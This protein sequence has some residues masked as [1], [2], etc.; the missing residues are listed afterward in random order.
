MFQQGKSS[1]VFTNCLLTYNNSARGYGGGLYLSPLAT[2]S[3]SRCTLVGNFA[4]FSRSGLYL[5]TNV[6]LAVSNSILWRNAGG[7]IETNGANVHLAF[8]LNDSADPLFVG[9]GT[10]SNLFVDGAVA[11]AGSGTAADPYCDLQ[12]GLDGFDFRLATNSPCL[13][14]ASDGGNQGATTG[15]G[16]AA[17]GTVATL[18]LVNGVYDIRGRNIIFTR[19]LQGNG[20]TNSFIGNGVFG[21]VEDTFLRDLAIT[22]ERWFGG[23]V[24]RNSALMERSRVFSNE[25]LHDGGGIYISAGTCVL[26]NS[27]VDVN[28]AQ[29]RGGGVW[30][31]DGL[32]FASDQSGLLDNQSVHH[33]GGL[34]VAPDATAWITNA[35]L[36]RLNRNNYNGLDPAAEGGGV[37][38]LDAEH[39]LV[40]DSGVEQNASSSNGG[41]VRVGCP[42]D[43]VHSWFSTN[44]SLEA[45]GGGIYSSGALVVTNCLIEANTANYYPHDGGGLFVSAGSAQLYDSEFLRN[46]AADF[47]GGLVVGASPT[48]FRA[49]RCGFLDNSSKNGGAGWLRNLNASALEV[50][51]CWFRT[52]Q[53][54][55]AG[56][57][58]VD[59]TRARII[60]CEFTANTS[61][62]V[63][64]GAVRAH[65]GT[66]LFSGCT[67]TRNSAKNPGGAA[68]LDG[69][70]SL[71]RGCS[72]DRNSAGTDG[73]LAAASNGDTSLFS[74]CVSTGCSAASRGGGLFAADTTKLLVEGC[75]FLDNQAGGSGGAM[76][77]TEQSAPRVGD[78]VISNC[79]AVLGGGFYADG[80]TV[81]TLEHCQFLSNVATNNAGSPDGGG[82]N[83]TGSAAGRLACCWFDG[84]RALDDGGALS[85]SGSGANVALTNCFLVN[86][87]AVNS[88]GGAH[89]TLN[90]AG[91]FQNCTLV[92]NRVQVSNG[93]GVYRETTCPVALDSSIVYW[94]QPDGIAQSGG[95]LG[96][97]YS[98]IQEPWLGT[99]NLTSDPL[100]NPLNSSLLD[101]SPCIDAGNPSPAFNDSC[102][103]PG[104]PTARNDMGASGGPGNCCQAAPSPGGP[105][106]CT[107]SVAREAA[108]LELL[109]PDALLPWDPIWR[110]YETTNLPPPFWTL[111]TNSVTRTNGQVLL[112]LPMQGPGR[113]FRLQS[114]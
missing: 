101:G 30:V 49:E 45:N 55:R 33:G 105:V 71:F 54:N 74:S 73:G 58:D 85:V 29:G 94:N 4:P 20:S 1:S 83:F 57:L 103:P 76:A 24:L 82:A 13:G 44:A 67:F 11:G 42:T 100:L 86:N 62:G 51:D 60:R 66:P 72:F 107:I 108:N 93:G 40:Q 9:W 32:G 5:S 80:T 59:N 98:C 112:M 28:I 79:S 65:W 46:E 22:G 31:G 26:R 8:S 88:G 109:W 38:A 43:M 18:N 15:T 99:G 78:T 2:N 75:S 106:G 21:Y 10:K 53:A 89:F 27:D 104:K 19:G 50:V 84:N 35:S 68:Y 56:A 12:I 47:G 70:T 39:L 34:F 3:L 6:S 17:G 113:F 48:L 16:G 64:G 36:V 110:L 23:I 95:S 114:P 111:V 14:T 37:Y 97:N 7:S 81:S 91:T 63:G 52:N 61:T 25:A 102:L 77:Y 92:S 96:V 69:S 90:G 41:G 87:Q